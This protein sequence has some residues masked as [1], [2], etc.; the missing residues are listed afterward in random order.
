M[1][2]FEYQAKDSRGAIVK[3]VLE[4]ADSRAAAS[5]LRSSGFTILTLSQKKAP[6]GIS[7]GKF[8]LT[9]QKVTIKDISVFTRQFSTMLRSGISAVRC[10]TVLEEQTK[11]PRFKE[12]ISTLRKDLEAGTTLSASMARFPQIFSTLYTN[13][14]AAGE[15]GGNL[16]DALDRLATFSEKDIAIR[17]KIKNALTYPIILLVLAV[18]VVILLVAG[19]LPTFTSMLNE[20]D[21]PIPLPTKITMGFSNLLL[22]YWYVFIILIVGGAFLLRRYIR[23]PKGRANWDRF[24][25]KLPVFGPLT[26]KTALSRFT[27]TLATLLQSGVPLLQALDVCSRAVDNAIYSEEIQRIANGVREGI[28]IGTLMSQSDLFPP[29]VVQMTTAGEESGALEELLTKVSAFYDQEVESAVANLTATIEPVMLVFMGG[30]VGF[31]LISLF[32]PYFA[33]LGGIK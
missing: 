1:P 5:R 25:M 6:L 2:Q 16:E 24:R 23:T 30:I 12:I 11:N 31:I 29:I 32:L 10:L 27:R 18:G 26:Q 9:S 7:L 17:A 28:R 20:L 21:V 8:T 13:M 22:G 15:V 14:V 19:V 4:A 33:L 3:G